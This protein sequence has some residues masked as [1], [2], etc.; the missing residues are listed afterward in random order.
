M[1][2]GDKISQVIGVESE[3]LKRLF[4]YI[5]V[6][7]NIFFLILSL[8]GLF[9]F[10]VVEENLIIYYLIGWVLWTPIYFLLLFI[11]FQLIINPII[12]IIDGFSEKK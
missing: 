12:F 1:M 5:Y 8:I 9:L 6:L 3:G 7:G 4:F 10:F 11:L 2:I